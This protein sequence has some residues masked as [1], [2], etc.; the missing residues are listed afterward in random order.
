MYKHAPDAAASYLDQS[1]DV[2]VSK[3]R[4]ANNLSAQE[5]RSLVCKVLDV[6][7]DSA[8][9]VGGQGLLG[10]VLRLPFEDGLDAVF[11]VVGEL[12]DG[13]ALEAE[14]APVLVDEG[15]VG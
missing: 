2:F 13:P 5:S 1:L 7:H 4:R 9:G 10:A 12:D 6:V 14:L 11:A 15:H 8:D 3:S